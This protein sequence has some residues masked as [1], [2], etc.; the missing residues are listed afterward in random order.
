MIEPIFDLFEPLERIRVVTPL[1][2]RFWD[3]ARGTQVTD[4]LSVTARRQ[5]IR[6]SATRAFRTASGIYA[7][8]GLPG[9]HD[10]EYP[11][12]DAV[13][14]Q[15]PPV[16][17]RFSV[18]V[19]D[20]QRRFLPVVFSINVP[21]WGIFPTVMR[22]SPPGSRLPGF[23]LFSAPTRPVPSTLAVVR[24][25]LAERGGVSDPPPA[26]HA[27]LEVQVPG[28]R[29]VYGL[30]DEQGR[31]AVMSPYPPFA[32]KIGNA[33]PMM[34]PPAAIQHRWDVSIRVQYAPQSL[35]VPLGSK[36]PE[37]RTI[38]S[39]PQELIWSTLAV[40]PGQP[41]DRLSTELIFGQELIVRT[42]AEPYLFV[43]PATSPL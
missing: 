43:G 4:G 35:V 33:S 36:I 10:L 37:L 11:T 23:Y 27:V 12:Q 16:T 9:L 2:I 29:P 24:A 38:L 21:H 14:T 22:S 40:Q 20:E 42:D 41:I 1:G 39:Q 18:E 31:A 8:Q 25:Q 32:A 17:A 19:Y 15:S 30:A 6:H 3:S 7:F 13:F 5:G 26:A 28:Q 34:S